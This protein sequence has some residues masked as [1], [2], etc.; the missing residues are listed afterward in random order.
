MRNG[1]HG[2]ANLLWKT[3]LEFSGSARDSLS[4]ANTVESLAQDRSAAKR[5][6]A[7]Y[8]AAGM[9]AISAIG[10]M[11]ITVML[12]LLAGQ[13]AGQLAA[14]INKHPKVDDTLSHAVHHQLQLLPYYSVFDYLS[15]TIDGSKVTLSGQVV[16]PTL[17]EHAQAAV[18]SIE[19]VLSV[20]N[21]IEVLPKSPPDDELRRDVY[22][23]IFEDP[24][25]KQYAVEPLPSIHIIV[26]NGV[27]T[28]EGTANSK[29]DKDLA[30]SKARGVQG[31]QTL[32]NHLLVRDK[33]TAAK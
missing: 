12:L 21:N 32:A 7:K 10:A 30:D 15:Y 25:L 24:A 6:E 8:G 20:V 13:L 23:A 2:R 31:V 17:K 33:Q 18:E 9:K 11:G 5:R 3:Q 29:A 14:Q 1:K 27:V 16:R 22:R 19:G 28:L 26:K 4:Y